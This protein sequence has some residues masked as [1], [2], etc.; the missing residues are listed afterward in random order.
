MT[1]GYAIYL[2]FF[3]IGWFSEDIYKWLKDKV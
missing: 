1:I 3:S 2:I